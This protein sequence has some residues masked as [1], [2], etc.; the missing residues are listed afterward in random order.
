MP[1][2]RNI[3]IVVLVAI[4]SASSALAQ[5]VTTS[6]TRELVIEQVLV[7]GAYF[8]KRV[9]SGVKTPTSLLDIPQSVSLM[10]AE[11]IN[12][13]AMTSI[14]EI[15]QYT[16][17]VSIGK[18]K[19][20]EIKLPFAAKIRPPTS[21]SMGCVTTFSISAH[22]ITLSALKS[23]VDLMPCY[24]VAAAAAAWL[25]ASAKWRKQSRASLICQAASIH[26]VPI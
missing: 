1:S 9:A 10:T 24:L 22:S 4:V 8:G 15:M 14:A 20:T 11:Q 3:V 2:R 5:D 17:G 12:D 26:L 13:Q 19:T 16:P 18:A 23:C 25:I 7:R 6:D 21:S